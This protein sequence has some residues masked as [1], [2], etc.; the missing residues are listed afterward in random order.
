MFTMLVGCSV[1]LDGTHQSNLTEPIVE[2]KEQVNVKL[3]IFVDGHEQIE[4]THEFDVEEGT[5]L[6]ELMEDHYRLVEVDGNVKCIEGNGQK[7]E[8]NIYWLY[9]VNGKLAE[10]KSSKYKLQSGDNIDWRL[11]KIN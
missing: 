8:E 2:E 11:E 10:S 4:F 6:L 3:K 5:T 9:Y 7:P 1:N